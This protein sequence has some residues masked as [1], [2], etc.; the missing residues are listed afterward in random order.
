[1]LFSRLGAP[2]A[3]QA[4]RS[5]ASAAAS[6]TPYLDFASKG[7]LWSSLRPGDLPSEEEIAAH[8]AAVCRR[9]RERRDR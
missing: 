2:L 8:G 9:R 6:A 7:P 3:L 5:M 1:M 4:H